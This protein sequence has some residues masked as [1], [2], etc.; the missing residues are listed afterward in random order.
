MINNNELFEKSYGQ[1]VPSIN[2]NLAK[3]N[4]ACTV[5]LWFDGRPPTELSFKISLSKTALNKIDTNTE[6]NVKSF[7]KP[8]NVLIVVSSLQNPRT[9][10]HPAQ[11]ERL[12]PS[13]TKNV[14]N[15]Q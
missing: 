14:Q 10:D 4:G 9:N 11:I 12:V 8:F 7:G 3:S 6:S 15:G 5:L 1:K 2:F 13:N